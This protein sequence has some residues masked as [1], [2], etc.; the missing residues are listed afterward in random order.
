MK[1]A[2]GTDPDGSEW[3]TILVVPRGGN[4][5]T[6]RKDAMAKRLKE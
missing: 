5:F 6:K 2:D 1:F 3:L 4:G